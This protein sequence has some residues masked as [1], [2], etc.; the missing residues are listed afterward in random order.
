[1]NQ[2]T[3][4]GRK[5]QYTV[6]LCIHRFHI[7]RFNRPPVENIPKQFQEVSKHKTRICH[8]PATVL[9][10]V[11]KRW[12]KVYRRTVHISCKDHAI[13]YKTWTRVGF[14]IWG[15]LGSNPRGKL[16]D[17]CVTKLV[18]ARVE[19]THNVLRSQV[20]HSL[21]QLRLINATTW[22]KLENRMLSKRSQTPKT[23]YCMIIEY[24]QNKQI[25][26]DR[27]Y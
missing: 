13:V 6:A 14:D 21:I 16:R 24:V 17:N 18:R 2:D 4:P 25:H 22:M 7:H 15:G 23:T 19:F 12:F 11:T 1:M 20:H 27:M 5:K 9:G 8:L 26:R 3:Q 10:K